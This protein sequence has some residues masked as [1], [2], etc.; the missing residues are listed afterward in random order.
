MKRRLKTICKGRLLI[1]VLA[2]GISAQALAE[3]QGSE[4]SAVPESTPTAEFFDFGDGTV[5]HRPTRLVWLRCPVG[6][7]WTGTECS[8]TASLLDWAAALNAAEQASDAGHTDWRL[9]NRNELGAI[10]ETR[11]H[12]PAING[13]IFPDV[14][15]TGFWTSSPVSGQDQQVWSIDFDQGALQPQTQDADQALR[16][17]RGGRL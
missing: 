11:C 13:A 9:P 4:N 2:L 3:C 15:A 10:V 5:L 7:S 8:G 14:P 6:Q 17:V 12:G 16:L 1:S